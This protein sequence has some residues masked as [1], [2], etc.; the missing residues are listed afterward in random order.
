MSAELRAR[1]LAAAAAETSPT[2]AGMRRRNLL[3]GLVAA[4]SGLVIAEILV[5]LSDLMLGVWW[6]V[7]LLH[8]LTVAV[9]AIGLSGLS[10]GLSACLPNFRE[11]DPSKIAVGFGG[12]LSLMAGLLFLAVTV[13]LM[14]VPWHVHAAIQA[15]RAQRVPRE[16]VVAGAAGGVSSNAIASP[17]SRSLRFGSFSKHRP[18]S[19]RTC[20]G[21]L[22]K[23]GSLVRT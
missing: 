2:R 5:V 22:L 20:G 6:G 14:A 10:V 8:V 19:R 18:S 9:L 13:A 3:I 17:I 23:S 15:S 16:G 12:T 1:V 21:A 4:A 11:S 7:L